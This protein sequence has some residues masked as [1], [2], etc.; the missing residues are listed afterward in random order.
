VRIDGIFSHLCPKTSCEALIFG[1][2]E[3]NMKEIT[4]HLLDD[5][6]L[7]EGQAMRAV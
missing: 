2:L 6:I 1:K 7:D 4:E 5:A 3:E